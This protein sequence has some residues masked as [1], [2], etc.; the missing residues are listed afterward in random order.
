MDARLGS[1][2]PPVAASSVMLVIDPRRISL[3]LDDDN[4]KATFASP[5]EARLDDSNL[6]IPARRFVFPSSPSDTLRPGRLWRTSE[7]SEPN[8]NEP[9]HESRRWR[10]GLAGTNGADGAL[11]LML[12]PGST[13]ASLV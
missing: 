7:L 11:S 9:I 4:V 13:S 5:S 10:R 1:G 8:A 3:E 6:C 2:L 12:V